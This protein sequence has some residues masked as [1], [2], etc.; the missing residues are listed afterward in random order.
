MH[1]RKIYVIH[2]MTD[3]WISWTSF[4]LSL[5]VRRLSVLHIN[6]RISYAS[7]GQNIQHKQTIL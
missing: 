5:N 7:H 1:G 2:S 4:Q 6:N 3:R